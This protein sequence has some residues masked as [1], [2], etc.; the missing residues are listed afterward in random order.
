MGAQQQERSKARAN[1][2]TEVSTEPSSP[3]VSGSA[4]AR[5]GK[6]AHDFNN[7]LTLVLG[8]GENLLKTLPK[9][10]PARPYA[11]EICRA[12]RE[13]ER[14]ALELASLTQAGRAEKSSS[15]AR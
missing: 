8:Y 11:E 10:H 3:R 13:G 4:P 2:V 7:I 9:G 15:A 1:A 5:L 12:A 6:I 14:L